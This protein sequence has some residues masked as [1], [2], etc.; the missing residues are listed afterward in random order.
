MFTVIASMPFESHTEIKSFEKLDDA[1]LYAEACQMQAKHF[2]RMAMRSCGF[3]RDLLDFSGALNDYVTYG[4]DFSFDV[5]TAP[6]VATADELV[7]AQAAID[8]ATH[9]LA[10]HTAAARLDDES[11]LIADAA[12]RFSGRGRNTDAHNFECVLPLK[13]SA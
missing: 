5:V 13:L 4:N 6:Q 3:E 12:N 8:A 10:T 9:D 11:A 7:R 2:E 1:Q